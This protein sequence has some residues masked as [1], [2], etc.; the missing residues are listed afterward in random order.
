MNVVLMDLVVR[1]AAT[2]DGIWG[3]DDRYDRE[4][5][6]MLEY[7]AAE[8]D[9]LSSDERQAF[10]RHVQEMSAS[11]AA[12]PLVSDDFRRFLSEFSSGFGLVDD[13]S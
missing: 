8:L 1:L 10:V 7:V 4:V 3:A 9:R 5:G 2:L 12:D 13:A 6:K 11:A